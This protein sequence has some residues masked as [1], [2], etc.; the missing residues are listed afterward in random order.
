[1]GWGPI[2]AVTR[3]FFREIRTFGIPVQLRLIRFKFRMNKI[4]LFRVIDLLYFFAI[5]MTI[6]L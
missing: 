3:V 1:M 6:I 4:S 2:G 5:L